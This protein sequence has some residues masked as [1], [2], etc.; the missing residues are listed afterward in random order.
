MELTGV[1]AL[2]LCAHGPQ[3]ELGTIQGVA[4]SYVALEGLLY[5]WAVLLGV[6]GHGGG[7]SLL[8][9]LSPQDLLHPVTQ[10]VAAG[11]GGVLPTHHRLIPLKVYPCWE[12]ER[13]R[14]RE[15]ERER[16]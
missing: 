12:K 6:G 7:V 13:K 10:G 3:G 16:V 2:I 1:A 14:E 8:R 9:R 5:D 11:K 15:R 4:Y